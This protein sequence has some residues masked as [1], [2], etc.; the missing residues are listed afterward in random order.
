MN[1]RATVTAARIAKATTS[2][3]L[4]S[5]APGFA[6]AAQAKTPTEAMIRTTAKSP[7]VPRVRENADAE[8]E[9]EEQSQREHRLDQGSRRMARAMIRS[10]QP[11]SEREVRRPSGLWIRL[12]HQRRL[13]AGPPG[14]ASLDRLQRVPRS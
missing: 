12:R 9:Q 6:R 3:A 1:R 5:T 7:W 14:P 8:H 2:P 10:G 13:Q 11:S 4:R